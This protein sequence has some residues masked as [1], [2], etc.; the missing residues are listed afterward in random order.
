MDAVGKVGVVAGLLGRG[1]GGGGG[2]GHGREGSLVSQQGTPEVGKEKSEKQR[3]LGDYVSRDKMLAVRDGCAKVLGAF[4]LLLRPLFHTL[5][6]SF[7]RPSA[8]PN[9]GSGRKAYRR[10]CTTLLRR[11]KRCRLTSRRRGASPSGLSLPAPFLPPEERGRLKRTHSADALP[12]SQPRPPRPRSMR[13]RRRAWPSSDRRARSSG[14]RECVSC[15]CFSSSLLRLLTYAPYHLVV[16]DPEL[17]A[18]CFEELSVYDAEHRD[19]IRFLIERK[20]S[21]SPL[22]SPFPYRH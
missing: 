5:T 4:S 18:Q 11:R 1:G 8:Q 12:H 10:S 19:R 17:Q 6:G 9:S 14:R 2:Q 22:P 7:P 13:A 15:S 16:T 21:S 20:V 3:F